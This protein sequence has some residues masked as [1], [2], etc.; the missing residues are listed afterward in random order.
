MA[1]SLRD[2]LY[3]RNVAGGRISDGIAELWVEAALAHRSFPIITTN[4]E[5]HLHEALLYS[6]SVAKAKAVAEGRSQLRDEIEQMEEILATESPII[7]LHGKIPKNEPIVDPPVL[8]ERDYFNSAERTQR[9]LIE[10]FQL[11]DLLIVGASLSDPPLL[12]ALDATRPLSMHEGGSGLQRYAL[13]PR[14]SVNALDST[15]ESHSILEFFDRRLQQFGVM[16]IYF[17]YYSQVGQFLTE[18]RVA[19]TLNRGEYPESARRYG[20][21]L[22]QWWDRWFAQLGTR[23]A[24]L[25]VQH[26]H[27]RA[28]VEASSHLG[29]HLVLRSRSRLS[30]GCVGR[31]VHTIVSFVSGLHHTLSSTTGRLREKSRLLRTPTWLPVVHSRQVDRRTTGVATQAGAG[32]RSLACRCAQWIK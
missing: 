4:Y 15:S 27:H 26:L 20:A 2:V 30:S 1:N 13:V 10:Q 16:G 25:E 7:Y 28:S 21:R 31:R 24:Y 14:E 23:E 17:D 5:T 9:M 18:M 3:Q 19:T 32:R 8:S 12:N 29:R 11:Y 22:R 6:A